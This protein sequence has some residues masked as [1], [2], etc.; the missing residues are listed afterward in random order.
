MPDPAFRKRPK[1][2]SSSSFLRPR[3]KGLAWA[4]PLSARSS[5]RTAARSKRK[6]QRR[7]ARAFILLCP[8]NRNARNERAGSSCVR[9][10]RRRIGPQRTETIARFARLQERVVRLGG[11][12]SRAAAPLRT[13]LLYL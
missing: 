1:S 13:R 5:N 2:D 8:A 10:R 9:D 6:T 3:K 12:I 11:R 4:L 7:A